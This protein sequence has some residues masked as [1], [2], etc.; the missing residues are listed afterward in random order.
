MRAPRYSTLSLTTVAVAVGVVL[1][2]L[3]TI[4]VFREDGREWM[5]IGSFYVVLLAAGVAAWGAQQE[6]RRRHSISRIFSR[7]LD[8]ASEVG[9]GSEM[10]WLTPEAV[11]R[12]DSALSDY[13]RPSERSPA[14]TSPQ[15]SILQRHNDGSAHM[16]PAGPNFYHVLEV[17]AESDP[18]LAQPLQ[19]SAKDYKDREYLWDKAEQLL[20]VAEEH[21][22]REGEFERSEHLAQVRRTR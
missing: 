2:T 22:R 20:K 1:W 17:L 15:N 12:L 21:L 10:I 3:A 7:A 4:P 5:L 9:A 14:S 6:V 11:D 13:V 16:L 18:G 19:E 8:V